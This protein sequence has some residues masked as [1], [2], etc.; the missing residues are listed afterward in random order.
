M[1]E[2]NKLSFSYT[3]AP[4]YVLESLHMRIR[5][6]EY[7]SVVG[8]NGSGKS[9]LIR[10]ALKFIRPTSGEIVCRAR[11]TGYVPQ[12]KDAGASGFPITVREMLFSYG[13]LLKLKNRRAALEALEQV[14]MEAYAS[15]LAGNLSGGQYQKVLIARALMGEPELLILDEPSTGIDRESQRDIYAFLK[16][17]NLERG[18]TIVSVE[19]NLDAAVKNSTSIYHLANGRGHLCTPEQYAREY[20]TV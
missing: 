18:I 15:E 3:G 17:L 9:T 16:R 7:V 19:H 13:K 1:L 12:K 8:D 6:G 14:G 20:L 10:L 11:H 4:P 5:D 2:A